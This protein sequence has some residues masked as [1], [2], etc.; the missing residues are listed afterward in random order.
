MRATASLCRRT[1]TAAWCVRWTPSSL[2]ARR[3][4]ARPSL[5]L[6]LGGVPREFVACGACMRVCVRPFDTW[7]VRVS[8][9]SSLVAAPC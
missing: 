4:L 7:A 2:E 5:R 9:A 6:S 3:R 8:T 1:A